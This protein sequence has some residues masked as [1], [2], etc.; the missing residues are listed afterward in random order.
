MRSDWNQLVR[1]HD[2]YG[3]RQTNPARNHR[4]LP[5]QVVSQA[6]WRRL[7]HFEGVSTAIF[8]LNHYSA[9]ASCLEEKA[10]LQPNP[11]KNAV[12]LAVFKHDFEVSSSKDV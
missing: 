5:S 6:T 3:V 7:R 4:N 8:P 1:D 2:N 12:L 10:D 9:S 11:K